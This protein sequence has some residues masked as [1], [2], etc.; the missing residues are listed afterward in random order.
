MHAAMERKVAVVVVAEAMQWW[1]VVMVVALEVMDDDVGMVVKVV[2]AWV[3][4]KVTVV[5]WEVGVVV[6][7][8][9]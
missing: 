3:V 6:F 5:E 1:K 2:D 7:L 9:W 8:A 4:A